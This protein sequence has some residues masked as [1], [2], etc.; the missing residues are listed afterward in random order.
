[1]Y[2]GEIYKANGPLYGS[3]V[4][5]YEGDVSEGYGRQNAIL[6]YN[7]INMEQLQGIILGCLESRTVILQVSGS[8]RR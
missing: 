7:F 4:G 6:A 2:E 1:M 3:G 5:H 8:A